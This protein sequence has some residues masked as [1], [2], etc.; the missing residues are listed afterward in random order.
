[1]ILVVVWM[2]SDA[3]SCGHVWRPDA[4]LAFDVI[5]LVFSLFIHGRLSPKNFLYTYFIINNPF[6]YIQPQT[7][8][9]TFIFVLF[10]S[11]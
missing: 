10:A 6:F 11:T 2:S 8:I 5:S 1:M 7:R 3:N 9:L 4:D